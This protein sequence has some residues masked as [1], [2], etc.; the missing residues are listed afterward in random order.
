MGDRVFSIDFGSAFTK[1]A[2]RRDPGAEAELVSRPRR[3]A[4]G[5]VDFCFPSVVVIDRRG[6]KPIVECGDGAVDR[7][8]GKG[9]EVYRNWK[10]W[11][12][13]EVPTTD[14][15]EKTSALDTL[16]RSDEF[17]DLADKF[18][19]PR[20]QVGYFRQL[21]AA[22][23]GLT[24]RALEPDTPLEVKQQ[25]FAA[26]L[27]GHYFV[28]LRRQVLE[29]CAKLPATGLNFEAIPVR[30]A[31]PAFEHAIPLGTNTNPGTQSLL[32]AIRRAGWPLHPDNPVVT[33]PYA[34][35]IG[36]LTHGQNVVHRG[37][38]QF[39]QMFEKGPFITVLKAPADHPTYRAL[40]I[41]VGAFT[42]DLATVTLDTGGK[43]VD[44]PRGEFVLDQQSVPLGISQLDEQI[45]TAIAEVSAEKGKKLDDATASDWET[46]RRSLYTE[47]KQYR[48]P[49]LV[50]GGKDE[51]ELLTSTLTAFGKSVAEEVMKFVAARKSADRQELILTGGGSVIPAVRDEVQRAATAN[52]HT[53][54]KIHAPD[55]KKKP[56]G[57][58]VDKL[59]EKFVRGGS[60][61]GGVSVYFERSFY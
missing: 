45:R 44:D 59:D 43:T 20:T 55:V 26:G 54:V 3:M 14:L 36:V 30:I 60:A 48:K 40:V 38:I 7:R 4:V 33:E 13:Q 8:P 61:T 2:L 46:I 28:W 9:V 27:A 1:V 34:N 15:A 23:E 56:G 52:G 18:G 41:D 51:A 10:K 11:L 29:A 57:P 19:V 6:L 50:I 12:F 47:G 17:R 39:A 53:Y 5:D 25:K 32:E 42:T 31:V 16:L 35:A 49:G 24:G 37:R 58:P 22:A 21:V